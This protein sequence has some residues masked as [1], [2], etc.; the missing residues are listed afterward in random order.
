MCAMIYH[1]T[2]IS[3]LIG[4]VTRRELWAS[5][6]QFLNDGTE[7]KYAR[8]LFSAEVEKLNRP[9]LDDGGY[10]VAGSHLYSFRVFIAC[11]CEESDLLSQWRGYG[12][13]QGY[14][15]GFDTEKLKALDFGDIY[16][17]QYGIANPSEYFAKELSWA[18]EPTAHPGNVDW[19][20]S[21]KLLPRLARVKHLSFAEEREWRILRQIPEFAL[22]DQRPKI[23]YRP[24]SM[25]PI[26]YLVMSF[27]PDCLREVV[28]GPG[29]H[30]ETRENAVQVMLRNLDL[31]NVNIRISKIPFRR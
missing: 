26:P 10:M 12:A 27:T 23:Q 13:D 6:C 2:T 19:F 4:I 11:F 7:L 8:D 15:L 16:P 29:S 25:G 30:T 3:G 14:A 21:Q 28:I 22:K 17:V 1:Y 24:S 5:D 20:E 9:S 18:T 31:Q